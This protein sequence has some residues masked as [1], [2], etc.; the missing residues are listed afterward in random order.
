[1]KIYKALVPLADGIYTMDAI[2]HNGEFWLVPEWIEAHNKELKMPVR[3]I[4]LWG[5]EHQVTIGGPF[6]DFVVANPI[7]KAVLN[8]QIPPELERAYTVIERPDIRIEYHGGLH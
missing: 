8:G 1:M 4:R 3:I 7:P 2:E 5:L 6:G